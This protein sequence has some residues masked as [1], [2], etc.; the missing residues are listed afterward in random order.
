MSI[1]SRNE[2]KPWILRDV[3][4]SN[5]IYYGTSFRE[6][7]IRVEKQYFCPEPNELSIS[8]TLEY[9]QSFWKATKLS[10]EMWSSLKAFRQSINT[11]KRYLE[12]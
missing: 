12:S 4:Q 6:R 9:R 8:T 7:K 5:I 2:M 1:V 11:D 3:Q 10:S